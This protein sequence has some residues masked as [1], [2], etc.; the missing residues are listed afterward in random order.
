MERTYNGIYQDIHPIR[1]GLAAWRV[2]KTA[3]LVLN[4]ALLAALEVYGRHIKKL[5]TQWPSARGL[6]Y[7]ADD[8][9]RAERIW[10]Q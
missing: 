4:V 8:A 6:V 5:V 1:A 7:Q 10:Q 2:F 3:C 9:A